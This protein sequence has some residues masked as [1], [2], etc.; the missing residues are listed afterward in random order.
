MIYDAINRSIPVDIKQRLTLTLEKGLSLNPETRFFFRAD[1]IAVPGKN[2]SRMMELFLSSRVPLNLAVV[3]AWLTR[4][5]WDAMAS[6]AGRGGTLFC[7]HQHGWSHVN[8]ETAGKKQEFG[9]SRARAQVEKDLEKGKARLELLLKHRAFPFFTPPWN[10]VSGEAMEVLSGL[11]FKGLSRSSKGLPLPPA[12]LKE[13][14]VHLDLHTRKDKTMDQGWESFFKEMALG[15]ESTACGIMI[16][17]MRMNESAFIFLEFMLQ[18]IV[19][20]NHAGCVR[21]SDL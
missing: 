20:Y 19:Q 12:G 7:W 9:P 11:G 15:M 21:F 6:L 13:F 5:R 18:L 14:P 2:F 17:H 10:R 16:H 4:K 3:P 1:D 8:H